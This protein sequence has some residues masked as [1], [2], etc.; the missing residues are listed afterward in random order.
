MYQAAGWF[1]LFATPPPVGFRLRVLL[2]HRLL[3]L[4]LNNAD[5]CGLLETSSLPVTDAGED[6][7]VLAAGVRADVARGR[8][9]D[10]TTELRVPARHAAGRVPGRAATVRPLHDGAVPAATHVRLRAATRRPSEGAHQRRAVPA[11]RSRGDGPAVHEVVAERVRRPRTEG[12]G[13]RVARSHDGAEPV[14]VRDSLLGWYQK[15]GGRRALRRGGRVDGRRR[16]RRVGSPVVIA[17]GPRG[18]G[19]APT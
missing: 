13:E 5:V 7:D 3:R 18:I 4:S 12:F 9:E 19:G 14:A 2:C 8:G 15:W 10:A 6:G 17:P 1:R 16:R 11:A